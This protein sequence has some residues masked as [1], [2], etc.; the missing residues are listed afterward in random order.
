MDNNNSPT[1]I[2][3]PMKNSS[4]HQDEENEKNAP[5]RQSLERIG[6]ANDL[7][8]IEPNG[9]QAVTLDHDVDLD[10]AERFVRLTNSTPQAQGAEDRRD[11]A[12]PDV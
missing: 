9:K 8:T 1:T 2:T 5:N 6:Q 10:E 7:E 12:A 4:P 11:F 3:T